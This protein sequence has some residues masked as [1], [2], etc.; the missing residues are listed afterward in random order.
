MPR[1]ITAIESSNTIAGVVYV[2]TSGSFGRVYKSTDYGN[3]FTDI[4]ANLPNLGKNTLAH[5]PNNGDDI[6]YLG[7]TAGVMA[8]DNTS[9]QWTAYD[10]DLPNINVR[11]LEI[12][13]NDNIMTAATYGRGVWQTGIPVNSP[14]T[15]V[16][17]V[18]LDTG[19]NGTPS[20]SSSGVEVTV[21]NNGATAISS[22]VLDYSIDGGAIQ[23]QTFTVNLAPQ[24]TTLIALPVTATTNSYDLQVNAQ[25]TNDAITVNNVANGRVS[26]NISSQVNDTYGFGTRTYATGGSKLWEV[27][28]PTA[29]TLNTA[30]SGSNSMV[31]ATNV[32]GNYSNNATSYLYTGC[33]DLTRVTSPFL[34]FEMAFE[35]E[36]DYD[37]LYMEYSTDNGTSWNIL[38][39]AADTD[40]YNS[41]T[42]RNNSCRLC[43]GA[44]W[45][46]FDTTIQTYR[47]SLASFV[48]ESS[49]VFRFAFESDQNLNFDGAVIDNLVVTGILSTPQAQS[50][51]ALRIYPNPSAAIFNLELATATSIDYVV[52]SASGQQVL[53]QENLTGREHQINLDG[54]ASGVYFLQVSSEDG[55]VTRKLL[56]Q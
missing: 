54:L 10:I 15:D 34:Q 24:Q 6:L 18:T 19:N 16:E 36:A 50:L 38:G 17:I 51:D 39:S 40:W 55:S 8:L 5:Q 52:Y 13:P 14:A 45:T 31:Y 25:L 47:Q 29:S 53:S 44:Q 42:Q 30:G 46:G 49:I 21:R 3:N 1:N 20:C 22:L 28:V 48:G 7:T 56:L 4:T 33:Y 35:I 26:T 2:A 32:D 12:N 37:V 11:D 41:S 27:G 43:R 23:S 9:T